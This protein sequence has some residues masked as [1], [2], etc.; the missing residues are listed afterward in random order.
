MDLAVL[1]VNVELKIAPTDA[2]WLFLLYTEDQ[3]IISWL[4]PPPPSTP[5]RSACGIS[6][7]SKRLYLKWQKIQLVI[8]LTACI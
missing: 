1:C 8:H 2:I 4:P 7:A 6:V 3:P 5:Y